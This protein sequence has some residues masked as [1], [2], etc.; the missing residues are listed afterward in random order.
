M[1]TPH[2]A[3]LAYVAQAAGASLTNLTKLMVDVPVPQ[4][5]ARSYGAELVSDT[6]STGSTSVTRTIVMQF[7]ASPAATLGTPVV[8]GSGAIV[9]VAVTSPGAGYVASPVTTIESAATPIRKARLWS[10]LLVVGTT[11]VSTGSGYTAPTVFFQGGL[12]PPKNDPTT[13]FLQPSCLQG[14]TIVD[15]GIGYSANA[16]LQFD[17]DLVDGGRLPAGTATFSAAGELLSVVITDAGQ[18]LISAALAFIYDPGPTSNGSGGG[19]GALLSTRLGV[20]EAA[21]GTPTLFDGGISGVT[22]LT[23]GG[24]YITPPTL[25]FSDPTGLGAIVTASMGLSEVVVIDPGV[26]Y[27][28]T[29]SAVLQDLFF[30]LFRNPAMWTNPFQDLMVTSLTNSTMSPVTASPV[31]LS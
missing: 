16:V 17:A 19:S 31:V 2:L 28:G 8:D 21:T 23:A 11:P 3:T 27:S 29:L 10:K 25:V 30:A 7:A 6:T 12:V 24:P 9:S 15:S 4:D 13:G 5:V 20:G 14:I 26:G 18:G 22:L 1:T